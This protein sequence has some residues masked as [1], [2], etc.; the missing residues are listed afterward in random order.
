MARSKISQDLCCTIGIRY[1]IEGREAN[2]LVAEHSHRQGLQADAGRCPFLGQTKA[3][4]GL[5]VAFYTQDH[6]FM[7][8]GQSGLPGRAHLSGAR[9]R[10]NIKN[11]GAGTVWLA[12]LRLSA[13]SLIERADKEIRTRRAQG[14]DSPELSKLDEAVA[15][16][17]VALYPGSARGTARSR[18]APLFPVANNTSF[19]LDAR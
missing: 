2:K 14:A 6:C 16:L 19:A 3:Q 15:T 5:V 13:E 17:G 12:P 7:R 11:A 18:F 9:H 10:S 1:R 4:A 8:L